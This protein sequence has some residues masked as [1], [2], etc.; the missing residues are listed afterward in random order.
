MPH[1]SQITVLN[2]VEE[3]KKILA[4]FPLRD[5]LQTEHITTN[6]FDTYAVRETV[7]LGL[8]DLCKNNPNVHTMLLLPGEFRH[9]NIRIETT[10]LENK[11]FKSVPTDF[12]S[13]GFWSLKL[14]L[15]KK[16]K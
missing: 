11:K 6:D 10:Y 5:F 4:R 12:G 16:I 1:I 2:G 13:H 7:N 3:R 9:A 15:A 14:I 8:E